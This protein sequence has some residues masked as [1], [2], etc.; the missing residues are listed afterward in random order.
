MLGKGPSILWHSLSASVGAWVAILPP[1]VEARL[2]SSHCKVSLLWG[3]SPG[4]SEEAEMYLE[5]NRGVPVLPTR[6]CSKE[7]AEI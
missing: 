4:P 1:A 7:R 5:G 6:L 2:L 3:M